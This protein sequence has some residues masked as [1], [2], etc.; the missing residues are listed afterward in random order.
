[1]SPLAIRAHNLAVFAGQPRIHVAAQAGPN[2]VSMGGWRARKEGIL[3][4]LVS[5]CPDILEH[6]KKNI[7]GNF[8]VVLSKVLLIHSPCIQYF[9]ISQPAGASVAVSI[10]DVT[11]KIV[12]VSQIILNYAGLSYFFGLWGAGGRWQRMP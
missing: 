8:E 1:M 7:S 5:L 9:C 6:S 2:S 11:T 10:S 3:D 4:T 12:R